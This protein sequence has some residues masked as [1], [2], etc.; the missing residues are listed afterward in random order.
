MVAEAKAKAVKPLVA[1]TPFDI[2]RYVGQWFTIARLDHW[3]EED[4]EN[5]RL[6]YSLKKDG[7][8]VILNVSIL[9][10]EVFDR[11]GYARFATE[12]SSAR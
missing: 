2:D 1:F 9:R 7:D 10:G 11:T 3:F 4:H 8:I 6:I 5:V 12:K